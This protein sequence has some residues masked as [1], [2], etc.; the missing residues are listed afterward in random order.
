MPGWNASEQETAQWGDAALPALTPTVDPEPSHTPL[1]PR[2]WNTPDGERLQHLDRSTD[3]VQVHGVEVNCTLPSTGQSLAGAAYQWRAA[4][5]PVSHSDGNSEFCK[6]R[7]LTEQ[8]ER[9]RR[10]QAFVNALPMGRQRATMRQLAHTVCAMIRANTGEMPRMHTGCIGGPSDA[11]LVHIWTHS[12]GTRAR[13]PRCAT[14][15]L[16]VVGTV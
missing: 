12:A 5:R 14:P 13:P 4:L 15:F 11:R 2:T 16:L 6:D 9:A 1:P 3:H 10:Q 8:A 7:E